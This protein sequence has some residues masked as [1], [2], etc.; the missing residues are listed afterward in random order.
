MC[1][2]GRAGVQVTYELD[3]MASEVSEDKGSSFTGDLSRGGSVRPVGVHTS[4]RGKLHL[5][6]A[7]IGKF[8]TSAALLNLVYWVLYCCVFDGELKQC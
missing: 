5:R 1:R 4:L 6:L 7:N 3:I 2:Q 8:G